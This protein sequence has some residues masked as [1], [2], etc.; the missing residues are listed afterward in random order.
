M[1]EY[2]EKEKLEIYLYLIILDLMNYM[3]VFPTRWWI[4]NTQELLS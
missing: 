2:T 1:Q 4:L 3:L